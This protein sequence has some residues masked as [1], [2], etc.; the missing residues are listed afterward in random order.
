[1]QTPRGA[2]TWRPKQ[3]ARIYWTEFS[4]RTALP[5]HQH[6][7]DARAC[8]GCRGSDAHHPGARHGPRRVVLV[9]GRHAAPR[10]GTPRG[11]AGPRGVVP[12]SLH[13]AA[14]RRAPGAPAGKDIQVGHSFGGVNIAL[15][16]EMFPEKVA[17]GRRVCHGVPAVVY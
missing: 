14:A 12:T 7:V 13:A 10:R 2:G 15:A 11:R 5:A 1:M 16:A 6:H 4:V 9:P 17:R 8:D 3:G